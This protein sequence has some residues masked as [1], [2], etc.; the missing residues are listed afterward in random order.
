[1][2]KYDE[3]VEDVQRLMDEGGNFNSIAVK[4]GLHRMTV[5]R[6]VEKHGLEVYV[7][8]DE[9]EDRLHLYQ[10]FE[11]LWE[12]DVLEAYMYDAFDRPIYIKKSQDTY[13]VSV[14]LK[15][16]YGTLFDYLRLRNYIPLA[17]N[18]NIECSY[19]N[20][21]HN[22]S[23][24]YRCN[25]SFMGVACKKSQYNRSRRYT[26]ENPGI[27]RSNN[28]RR[29]S[30]QYNLPFESI[31]EFPFSSCALTGEKDYSIDHFIAIST[32]HGGS[33][34]ENYMPLSKSL[35][36][37]K[38]DKN[39]FNWIM[40]RGI[41]KGLLGL[42]VVRLSQLNRITVEEY[43]QFVYWC[44]SNK[45]NIDEIKRDPRHSIEIWREATGKHFPLPRYVYEVGFL[46]ENESEVS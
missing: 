46:S 38:N 45:R 28:Y 37:S 40:F 11:W 44:Y 31:K 9:D 5:V 43:R 23:D 8:F 15:N 36:S 42:E 14:Y 29:R 4:L 16:N 32:G 30:T 10:N 39:P 25:K 19:C 2:S 3:Y 33:Y 17:F 18:V 21:F 6:I 12:E 7:P 26:S 13:T 1:M 35:N 41:D 24:F 27:S 22:I 20:E 34:L